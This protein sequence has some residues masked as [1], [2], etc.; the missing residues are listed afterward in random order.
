LTIDELIDKLK[1]IKETHPEAQTV[2]A[3]TRIGIKGYHI[4]LGL[5]DEILMIEAV[6]EWET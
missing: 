5:K 1:A 4:A 3:R 6:R 2:A